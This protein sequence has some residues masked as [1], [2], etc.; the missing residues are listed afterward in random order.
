[1]SDLTTTLSRCNKCGK[2]F[3]RT[4]EY[5]PKAKT[6]SDGMQRTCRYCKAARNAKWHQ[7]NRERRQQQAKD[8]RKQH[9]DKSRTYTKNWRNKNK[10]YAT[11]KS[12]EWRRNNIEKSREIDRNWAK[13]HPDKKYNMRLRRK[14]LKQG[15]L[16][17]FTQ[18]DWSR[19]LEYWHGCCAYCGHQRGLWQTELAQDHF[20]PQSKGGA[21]TPDNILPACNGTDGCNT[22]KGNRDAR[23]WLEREYG[24]R[25][26]K[27]VLTRI[28]A[29]FDGLTQIGNEH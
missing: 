25:K 17:T 2:D 7:D 11:Q 8:W 23:E 4:S 10:A 26:T 20:I 18:E 6:C 13:R 1:M 22:K 12:L 9:P 21:Y 28:Q 15:L 19:C 24:T 3:P 5:F 16:A 14:A 27:Q 29:Y